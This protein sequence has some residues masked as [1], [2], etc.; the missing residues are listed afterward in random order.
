MRVL[1][2]RKKEKRNYVIPVYALKQELNHGLTL[3]KVHRAIQ[4]NQEAWLKRYIDMNNELR[5][6][7]KNRFE[8]DFFKLMNNC[9]WKNNGECK[10]S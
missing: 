9:L 5:K 7:A 6:E 3:K 2:K 8:K 1:Y 10:K 4:F